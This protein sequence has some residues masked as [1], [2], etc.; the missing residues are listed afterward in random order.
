M[1][2]FFEERTE[3][4]NEN[5]EK[6]KNFL[7]EKGFVCELL[8]TKNPSIQDMLATYENTTIAITVYG[9]YSAAKAIDVNKDDLKFMFYVADGYR[10]TTN[11]IGNWA[12]YNSGLP[13]S[14]T[15]HINNHDHS[16]REITDSINDFF[17]RKEMDLDGI[18]NQ[19]KSNAELDNLVE[20][21]LGKY[22]RIYVKYRHEKIQDDNIKKE[23]AKI[24]EKHPNILN[25]LGKEVQDFCI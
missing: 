15:I 16:Y 1:D 6:L 5:T 12:F 20:S 13:T 4:V 23:L 22:I 25:D 2:T 10:D 17:K 21:E 7:E 8:D 19:E 11:G 24:L 9:R 3:A 18:I 14:D